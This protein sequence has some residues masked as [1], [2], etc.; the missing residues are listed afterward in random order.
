M[1]TPF[2]V[3]GIIIKGVGGA[4]TILSKGKSYVCNA[5]GIFRNRNT[6]PLVGDYAVISVTDEDKQQG[7]LH[8]IKPRKNQL[9]RPPVVNIDQVII[10]VATAQPAFN[11]GLLDRFL[12]LVAYEGIDVLICVNKSD[13]AEKDESFAPYVDAGYPLVYTSAL[14]NDGLADLRY[15]MA[16]K[17]NVFAGPSGVG[18]SSLINALS[19]K[20]TLATGELSAKLGRGKHTTRHSEIFALSED[21]ADGYC[22]DTPGFSSLDTDSIPRGK[23]PA[24][25]KEFAQFA[26][27]CRF[28]D[29]LH[30][31]ERDC[32]VKA[33]IGQGISPLRHESYVKILETTN[34]A[35]R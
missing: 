1:K 26:D 34:G 33:R 9:R 16:G 17:V 27:E 18:K 20:L 10:T 35:S 19:P 15:H 3:E 14:H 29:C 5:R 23:L 7:T 25:F 4:Y 24:L 8:T 12:V 31:Q 32:A 6:T 13:I 22:V 28:A 2:D 30:Y 11:A 21:S